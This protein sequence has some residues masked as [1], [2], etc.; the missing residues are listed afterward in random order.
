MQVAIAISLAVVLPCHATAT[1]VSPAATTAADAT[2]GTNAR[3]ATVTCAG[4]CC[5]RGAG[6]NVRSGDASVGPHRA[7]VGAAELLLRARPLI[8]RLDRA[9]RH[10]RPVQHLHHLG[11]LRDG[12]VLG[13]RHALEPATERK[14]EM[15]NHH[16]MICIVTSLSYIA[17]CCPVPLTA[18][19]H[20]ITLES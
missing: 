8:L 9:A 18:M 13:K 20:P 19:I 16:I 17:I 4:R 2:E 6:A 11:C 14:R 3:T 10:L 1:E 15:R 12:E 5:L 7:S